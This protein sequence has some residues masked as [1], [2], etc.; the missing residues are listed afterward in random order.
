M[1]SVLIGQRWSL[2]TAACGTERSLFK[3]HSIDEDGFVTLVHVTSG[4]VFRTPRRNLERGMRAAHLVENPDG[5]VVVRPLTRGRPTTPT[6]RARHA[7]IMLEGGATM[8]HVKEYFRVSEAT[9]RRWVKEVLADATQLPFQKEA[10]K[11]T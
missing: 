1:S 2:K 8:A 3:V 5:S 6:S 7:V 10:R 4:R 9:V 11:C